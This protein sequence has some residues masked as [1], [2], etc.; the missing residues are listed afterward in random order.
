M[1]LDK[2]NSQLQSLSQIQEAQRKQQQNSV[3]TADIETPSF[4]D[5]LKQQLAG[6][7]EIKFSAHAEKRLQSRNIPITPELMQRLQDAV[8]KVREKGG[9]E[10]LLVF[11]KFSLIVSVKN[12][13]VITAIDNQ[14]MKDN[15]F[16]NI[17]SAA[18]A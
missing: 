4:K 5:V 12:N 18:F 1:T 3:N 13:T 7:S 10:S 6:N 16:T 15:V 17:D 9:N 14:G 2:I 11:D 8:S